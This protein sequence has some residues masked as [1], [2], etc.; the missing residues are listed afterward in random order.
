MGTA[1][2]EPQLRELR[3]LARSVVLLFD[4]DNAGSEAALRGLELAAIADKDLRVRVALAAAGL[5]SRRGR[6]GRT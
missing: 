4:A 1:L 5:R 2:T 6:G 3:K